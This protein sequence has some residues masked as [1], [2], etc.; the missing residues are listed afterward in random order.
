M[1]N[2]FGKTRFLKIE[3]N[4]KKQIVKQDYL[5]G[6]Y[7]YLSKKNAKIY[8]SFRVVAFNTNTL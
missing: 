7:R 3:R 4:P 8:C 1:A 6:I 2:Y 5:Y